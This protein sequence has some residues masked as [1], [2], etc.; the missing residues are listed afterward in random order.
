MRILSVVFLLLSFLIMGYSADNEA[1]LLRFPAIH[2]D[3]IAFS[4]GGELYLVPSSGGTARKITSHAGYE[5][6][7][8]F[9]YDGKWLAFTGQYD[10]N[11]EV[12]VMPSDG[13]VPERLTVTATLSRD[14]VGDRMGPNNIV[15]GW[16]HDNSH[17]V[18]RSRMRDYNS[19]LGHLY[20]ASLKGDIPQ[21]IE[22]PRGGF[23]SFSPDD[24]KLA[25]NRIFREFRTWKRYR[26][27][28]ADDIWIYDFKSKKTINIT[29]N[30]AQDIIPMWHD[31]FI[32]FLSDRDSNKRM[33]LYCYDLTT[34]Q[35]T[36]LTFFED[37]DVKF[38]SIGIDALVFENGGYIYK[39][40]LQNRKY[41]KVTVFIKD[42][43]VGSRKEF[44]Q[45]DNNIFEYNIAPDG[46]RVLF[47]ARGE[48]FTVPV[49]EGI[50]RN[51]TQTSGVHERSSRWS[52]DG[53]WI[54]WISDASGEDEI[55]IMAQNGKGEAKQ[56]TFNGDTYKYSL[57]WSPDSKKIM[58]SDKKLRLNYIDIES[59]KITVV[60]KAKIW[61]I[62]QYV[63]SPDSRFLAYSFP[64]TGS[65]SKIYIYSVKEN[66][67]YP[68]TGAWYSSG[69]PAFSTDGKYLFYTSATQYSPVMDWNDFNYAYI[70]MSKIYMIALAKDTKPAFLPQ[71]DEVEIAIPDKKNKDKKEK[72]EKKDNTVR[73]DFV[74]IADR[75]FEIPV[76]ASVYFNLTAPEGKLYYQRRGKDDKEI[77]LLMY[78]LQEKK[79]TELGDINGY[80]I[81]AD[82]KKMLVGIK[83]QYAV[84]DLPTAEIKPEKFV[85]ISQMTV[86]LD[87][88]EEW[89]QIF[90]QCWR[91][92]RD[93]FYVPNMHGVD[94]KLMKERYLPLVDFVNHRSDLNYVIGEMIG[95]LNI[96]HAYV[97]GGNVPEVKRIKTGLLGAVLTRDNKSGYYKVS[98]IL[99][100][101]NWDPKLRSPLQVPGV[102]VKE[103][104]YILAIDGIYVNEVNNIYELLVGK[105]DK[106]IM[107]TVNS[108]PEKR[109]SR[110]VLVIPIADE[111][112][113]YYYNWVENNI[114][115]VSKATDGKVGYIHIPDM[116]IEGLNEF[117][118]RYYPQLNKK[119]VIIDVRGNGGGFV[120]RMIIERLRREI[121]M[122]NMARNTTTSPN[123]D[124]M[125]YGPKI[126][127]MDE[128]S[129]SDGDL[130]PY[131]FRKNGLGKLV[132]KRSWG[133]VV[134]IR[135]S[136]PIVDGGQLYKPEF[137]SFDV[138]GKEWIIEGHGV[139]PDVYVDNDPAK[140]YEGEDEQLNKAI[141]LIL[142]ELNNYNNKVPDVIPAPEK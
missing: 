19:F 104:D 5:M 75:V 22:L 23:C 98:K 91:N 38:P 82:N 11:T 106:E 76:K 115:K 20:L 86:N 37:Y 133:G 72:K 24:S 34:E 36:Q 9:S 117:A 113:L 63:W 88:K 109:G 114:A 92:M 83:K 51:L 134:G 90:N 81:S 95:E 128:F 116:S 140:E 27:G 139:D 13:G 49:K 44:I 52:P 118:R 142:I 107:V 39:F 71:N 74:G 121:T 41:E 78:D 122:I 3:K 31:N 97:G 45:A 56:L 60:E 93:F 58:W 25:Y 126:C 136:L 62:S 125:I 18:F 112:P 54:A 29:N 119:A 61:E 30:P 73:I 17:I 59:G 111:H 15:M 132:G 85:D 105:A 141:E 131:R 6:F 80:E 1:R 10:G 96:G 77:R 87:R 32:Y 103:G 40:N 47:G 127:L 108:K 79:E 12:Y 2:K 70:D 66:K 42:D 123:P 137:A 100:G 26:G 99:K 14:D 101:L 48:V 4:Y 35:T 110:E 43:H 69:S 53:K 33:N 84:I 7:P 120:S 65:V 135:G 64:E 94:W 102:E 16:K 50:T 89:R 67:K 68:V 57:V 55:Y 124:A 130:F 21:E 28:M 138:E 129:A 8:R 46:K